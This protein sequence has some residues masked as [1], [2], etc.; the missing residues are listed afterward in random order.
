VREG[1]LFVEKKEA[2]ASVRQWKGTPQDGTRTRRAE[3]RINGRERLADSLGK[4]VQHERAI[5]QGV[6]QIE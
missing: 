5:M 3:A 6:D 1:G 2:H 4:A